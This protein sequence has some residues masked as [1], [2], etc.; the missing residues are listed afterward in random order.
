MKENPQNQDRQQLEELIREY[1]NLKH[2]RSHSFL[3]E[4]SFEKVISYFEE[5]EDLVKALEAVS[6]IAFVNEHL[7][8]IVV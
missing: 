2:G 7:N 4:E 5:N 6:P 8:G 3:E 1:E